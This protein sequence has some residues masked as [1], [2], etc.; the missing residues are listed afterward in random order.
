MLTSADLDLMTPQIELLFKGLGIELFHMKTIDIK[1]VLKEFITIDSANTILIDGEWGIGKTYQTK[2][3][4]RELLESQDPLAKK[5]VY[6]SLYG[7]KNVSDLNACYKISAP[8]VF[9]TI[10]K[11]G[12]PFT[13]LVPFCGMQIAD[14]I[15]NVTSVIP[16]ERKVRTK[17]LFIFDDLERTD[18]SLSY[19]Q[20]YGFFNTLLL[21]G[22]RILCLASTNHIKNNKR[23]SELLDFE[24]KTFRRIIRI[25]EK[26]TDIVKIILAKNSCPYSERLPDELGCNLRNVERVCY[27]YN[28]IKD[29]N[30]NLW[31]SIRKL[32]PEEQVL[33]ACVA[34]VKAMFGPVEAAPKPSNSY[35]EATYGIYVEKYGTEIGPRLLS[36]YK[37]KNLI[38]LS[39]QSLAGKLIRSA[40][41]YFLWNDLS[42][43][44]SF[45][46]NKEDGL[47]GTNYFLLGDADK[48]RYRSEFIQKIKD[49]GKQPMSATLRRLSV[50]WLLS[51]KLDLLIEEEPKI[52]ELLFEL[53]SED[54]SFLEEIRDQ[55]LFLS[56]QAR[57][58]KEACIVEPILKMARAK[59]DARFLSSLSTAFVAGDYAQLVE[60]ISAMRQYIRDP[61]N[62]LPKVN[63]YLEEHHFLLP[64]LASSIS[65]DQWDYCRQVQM[66]ACNVGSG[67]VFTTLLQTIKKDH[68]ESE[69][70][71]SKCNALIKNAAIHQD[72]SIAD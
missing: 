46:P 1:Q 43:I 4:I 15:D 67:N 68:Q 57:N 18:P 10:V 37:N 41:E 21:N 64:D 9:K 39:N 8:T 3:A 70:C 40:V 6:A 13:S 30:A 22:C 17:R 29:A 19:I 69:S 63:G 35:D 38:T 52:K 72:D 49:L 71:M 56:E 53:A 48:A 7:L 58:E 45:A 2:E 5:V 44:Q 36:I 66:Y 61:R 65:Q 55:L 42:G 12:A 16:E 54:D 24:E 62:T 25:N 59:E 20:L 32:F 27:L 50:E 51:D 23:R 60:I 31:N 47:L 14:A 33:L 34:A 28:A 11:A 26:P